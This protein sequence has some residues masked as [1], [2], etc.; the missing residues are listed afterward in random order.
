LPFIPTYFLLHSS[1][2]EEVLLQGQGKTFADQAGA[3]NQRER[4]EVVVFT[5]IY[6][7]PM[8][9]IM[10]SN[11]NAKREQWMKLQLV[12]FGVLGLIGW[13]VVEKKVC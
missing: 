8:Y 7:S 1:R 2:H 9:A 3:P 10:F 12:R 13:S 6:T 4:A 5:W 11:C